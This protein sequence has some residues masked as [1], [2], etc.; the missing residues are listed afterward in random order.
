[1]AFG[2]NVVIV[3][4]NLTRDPELRQL[5]NGGSVC[6]I[7]LAVNERVKDRDSGE[8]RDRANF[9]DVTVWAGTGENLA[10]TLHKGSPLTVKGRLHWREWEADDGTKRQGVQIIA[11]DVVTQKD[12]GGGSRDEGN[13]FDEDFAP[14][15]RNG[16]GHDDFSPA[17]RQATPVPDADDSD[18]PF[19]WRDRFDPLGL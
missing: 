16:G 10:R 6:S 15:P 2:I 8:W 3:S 17:P 1:M 18:I 19:A 12:G 4:G 9:F 5:A 11:D 14:P 7:R 13:R